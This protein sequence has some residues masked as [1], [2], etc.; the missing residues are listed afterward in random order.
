VID[1][2]PLAKLGWDATWDAAFAPHAADSRRPARVVAA[3]RDAWTVAVADGHDVQAVISGRFRFDAAAPG[4]LPAVGDWVAVD[5]PAAGTGPA[6]IH[7]VLARRSFFRRSAGDASRRRSGAI[8]NE[9]VLA[10]NVDVAL[11][12]SGLDADF[13]VRRLERYVSVAYAGGVSPVVVLNK[14]DVDPDLD[15]HIIAAQAV[16]P[17]VPVHAISARTGLGVDDLVAR[18]VVP[19]STVVFLGS[20]GVGKSTLVNR[21]LGEERQKTNAVREDDSRGR[22]T[23]TTREL[24]R[25][26]GGALVVDTPGIRALEVTWAD[27]G[28]DETFVDIGS[29]AASCRFS[30]CRHESEPGCAVL[31]AVADGRFDASRL[32]SHRRLER[33]AAHANRQ[34]DR[35][36]AAANRQR[37]KAVHKSVHQHMKQKYGDL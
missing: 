37:W 9:Q 26:P 15:G 1:I 2:D 3:Y 17:G 22:H 13:D 28:L 4:D 18:H 29:I 23:T 14:A 8:A 21:L 5:V 10:A 32:A 31:A 20:S 7:A 19:G 30:D 27:E 12:L 34:V 6:V 11:L 16:A 25:L 24:L 35:L 33:E 36:A